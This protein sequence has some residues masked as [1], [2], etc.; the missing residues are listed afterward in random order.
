MTKVDEAA[1]YGK[2]TVNA[3]ERLENQLETTS[4]PTLGSKATSDN[5]SDISSS[6]SRIESM[7]C[8]GYSPTPPTGSRS[9]QGFHFSQGDSPCSM[10][11]P[12]DPL[13]QFGRQP[14]SL[15]SPRASLPLDARPVAGFLGHGPILARRRYICSCC[16]FN[17]TFDSTEELKLIL[18]T[19]L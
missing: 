7:I 9:G 14:P 3:L 15:L 11:P 8:G 16:Y 10:G 1:S 2:L 17:V 12:M 4:M 19:S 18:P 13:A 5:L 6:L